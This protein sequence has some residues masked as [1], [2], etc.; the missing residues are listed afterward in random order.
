MVIHRDGRVSS[1]VQIRGSI[2]LYW[3][4][5]ANLKYTP[6]VHIEK[7]VLEVRRWRRRRSGGG[8]GG[9]GGGGY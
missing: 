3:S 2:P 5:P 4:S 7:T 9:G 1:F 6:P 8:G